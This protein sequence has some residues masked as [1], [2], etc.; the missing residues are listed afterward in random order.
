MILLEW[1]SKLQMTIAV[2]YRNSCRFRL[3]DPKRYVVYSF[4]G[5]G[6]W[7]CLSAERGTI[8]QEPCS[9]WQVDVSYMEKHLMD[10]A[11]DRKLVYER[12]KWRCSGIPASQYYRIELNTAQNAS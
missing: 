4:A 5:I 3:Q 9:F 6:R 11:I 7:T 2:T 1:D 12:K 10:M 8:V